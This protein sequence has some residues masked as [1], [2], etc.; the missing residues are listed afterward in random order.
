MKSLCALSFLFECFCVN[1]WWQHRIIITISCQPG[2]LPVMF[3]Y[4]VSV[5]LPHSILITDDCWQ[6]HPGRVV[7][8]VKWQNMGLRMSASHWHLSYD[9]ERSPPRLQ[10]L[11]TLWPHQ[12]VSDPPSP[13][14]S[15]LFVSSSSVMCLC[16]SVTSPE[17]VCKHSTG[18]VV[19]HLL[20]YQWKIYS[21]MFS[22]TGYG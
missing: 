8:G 18:D 5:P 9:S 3:R 17:F 21:A 13:P 11:I 4:Q 16:S 20:T 22:W 19:P 14:P 7:T 10:P 2:S 12:Y 1:S 6:T 15:L